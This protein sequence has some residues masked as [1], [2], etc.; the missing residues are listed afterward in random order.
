MGS[1]LWLKS[2]NKIM[3]GIYMAMAI[4]MVVMVMPQAWYDRI[5]T[6]QNYQTDQSAVGRINAWHTA[7]NIAED[8]ITGGGLMAF[9]A[10]TF[11]RYAPDPNN[12]HDVHSIYFE[13]MGEQG[14]VG[15]GLFMLLGFLAWWKANKVIKRCK[16][17]PE[18]KW[19]VDLAAMVQVSM[20]GYASGGAFLG[21]AY[22]DLYYHLI[23]IVVIL[24]ALT[25]AQ[26]VTQ[27]VQTARKQFASGGVRLLQ[28]RA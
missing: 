26:E 4:T 14:F 22:F 9:Q 7:F 15:F 13:V 16:K 2:R 1:F 17:N 19:A 6:I 12:V 25:Q 11:R 28:P 3:T 27:G 21:L 18:Q 10:P 8:R 23:A 24:H 5:N 20:I